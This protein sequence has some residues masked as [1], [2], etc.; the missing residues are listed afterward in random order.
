[1]QSAELKLIHFDTGDVIATSGGGDSI[2]V[3]GLFDKDKGNATI[4]GSLNNHSLDFMNTG[5]KNTT[6]LLDNAL[7]GIALNPLVTSDTKFY[8]KEDVTGMTLLDLFN[9]AN[10]IGHSSGDVG[11][12]DSN[13]SSVYNGTYIWD[14]NRDGVGAFIWQTN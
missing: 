3:L 8:G 11:T 4:K 6:S 10:R 7:G 2:T 9:T 5:Y 1:M 12:E 14:A 13:K